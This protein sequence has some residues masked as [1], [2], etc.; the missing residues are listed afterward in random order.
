M[1]IVCPSCNKVQEVVPDDLIG[2]YVRC[3]KCHYIFLWK[4]FV[5]NQNNAQIHTKDTEPDK[6]GTFFK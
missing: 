3:E 5:V 6:P 4:K 2:R 1:K